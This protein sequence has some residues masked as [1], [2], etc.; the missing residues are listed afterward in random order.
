MICQYDKIK[1]RLNKIIFASNIQRKF[2][3]NHITSIDIHMNLYYN[4]INLSDNRL[5]LKVN[6]MTSGKKQI[7]PA[8]ERPE[9]V[10]FEAIRPAFAVT[11]GLMLSQV[12]EMTGLGSSTIQNWIKRGWIM[13]P[14]EKKYSE[15]QV[16]RIL[17]IN[18]LRKS[19][20]L[21]NILKLM[22]C[23]NGDV[24]D[25]SDDII[26]DA[27]LYIYIYNIVKRT[28]PLDQFTLE[29]LDSV[30]DEEIRDY[31]GTA[32]GYTGHVSDAAKRLH[33]ALKIILLTYMSSELRKRAEAELEKL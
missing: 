7:T 18:M 26:K 17:I 15:R 10:D 27:D 11:G 22:E 13:S 20:Q 5:N 33:D 9:L 1:T 31:H 24:E 14:T 32:E 12:V 3:K 6:Q 4:H 23:V 29:R 2:I 25:Q 16:A 30:I 8:K 28:E 19:M 21:E